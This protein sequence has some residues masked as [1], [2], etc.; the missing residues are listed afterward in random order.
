MVGIAAVVALFPSMQQ[1]N[2]EADR[3]AREKQEALKIRL[4]EQKES[5]AAQLEMKA[6][7]KRQQ[8]AC[9]LHWGVFLACTVRS[10]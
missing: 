8:E 10:A 7:L 1:A 2:D 4:R 9:V 5:I 6:E 3:R